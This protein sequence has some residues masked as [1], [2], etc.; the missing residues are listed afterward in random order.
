MVRGLNKHEHE[1]AVMNKIKKDRYEDKKAK[2]NTCVLKV[3]KHFLFLVVL[4]SE[5]D[6]DEELFPEKKTIRKGQDIPKDNEHDYA[7]KPRLYGIVIQYVKTN[8]PYCNLQTHSNKFTVATERNSAGHLLRTIGYCGMKNPD[9]PFRFTV[10]IHMNGD[11]FI[12]TNGVLIHEGQFKA[13]HIRKPERQALKEAFEQGVNPTLVFHKRLAQI[14]RNIL[15]AE[16]LDGAGKRYGTN[17]D[18][19]KTIP[20][21]CTAYIMKDWK[22]L[23][24]KSKLKKEEVKSIMLY[25]SVVLNSNTYEELKK[26]YQLFCVYFIHPEDTA[27]HRA[28]KEKLNAAV[29]NLEKMNADDVDD[30]IAY[31]EKYLQLNVVDEYGIGDIDKK[32]IDDDIKKMNQTVQTW[33]SEEEMLN[34]FDSNVKTGLY[35]I[36]SRR[37]ITRQMIPDLYD[38]MGKGLLVKEYVI[39]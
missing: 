21:A 12:N 25:C 18:I 7:I 20:H 31:D 23:C 19:Q 17:A 33:F 16:N 13:R 3:L 6:T 38:K 36:T 15:K 9:C 1:R 26:N 22:I 11:V 10:D 37:T 30:V 32:E 2:Q 24:H 4:Y 34:E 14:P 5:A 35:A 27:Q 8:N 28:A 39:L 29:R